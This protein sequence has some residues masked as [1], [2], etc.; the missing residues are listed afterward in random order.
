[1]G[2]KF[3]YRLLGPRYKLHLMNI[4]RCSYAYVQNSKVNAMLPRYTR[5]GS[6]RY[7]KVS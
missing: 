1:M 7:G 2:E 3:Y 5:P 6:V 4:R